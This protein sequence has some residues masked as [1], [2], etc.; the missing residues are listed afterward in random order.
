MAASDDDPIYDMGD[1]F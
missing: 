1:I